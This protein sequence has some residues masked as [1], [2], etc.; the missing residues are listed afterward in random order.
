MG[1][2][3][4]EGDL[5]SP[6]RQSTTPMVSWSYANSREATLAWERAGYRAGEQPAVQQNAYVHVNL[7]AAGVVVHTVPRPTMLNDP[8]HPFVS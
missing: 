5:P 2:T 7:C 6:T 8:R 3:A 1:S 4:Q